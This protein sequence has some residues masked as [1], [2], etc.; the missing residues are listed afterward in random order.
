[1]AK[2]EENVGNTQ[3]GISDIFLKKHTIGT[4]KNP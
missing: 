3:N 1:M 2:G 4:G